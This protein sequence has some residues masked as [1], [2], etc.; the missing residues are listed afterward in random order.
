MAS[1]LVKPITCRKC[2]NAAAKF[3]C[4]TCKYELCPTCKV[5]HANSKDTTHHNIVPY[6]EKLNPKYLENSLCPKHEKHAPKFWCK[7][8]GVPICDSCIVSNEHIGHEFSDIT[9]VLSEQRDAML[10]ETMRLREVTVV[11][12]EDVLT[13]A[14]GITKDYLGS[15]EELEKA[16]MSRAKEM[17]E[18]VETILSK[19]KH[20]LQKMKADGLEKLKNQEKNLED[21]IHHLKADMERYEDQLRDADLNALIQFNQLESTGQSNDDAKPP[22]LE[23]ASLP[24][25]TKGQNEIKVMQNVFGQLS[26]GNTIQQIIELDKKCNQ[27]ATITSNSNKNSVQPS[28]ST[29]RDTGRSLIPNPSVQ[30]QFTVV[31]SPYIACDEQGQAWMRGGTRVSRSKRTTYSTLKLVGKDG[32]VKDETETKFAINDIAM[33]S[34]GC[35]LLANNDNKSIE[36]ISR[37]KIHNTLFRTS[38]VPIGLCCLHNNDIVVISNNVVEFHKETGRNVIIYNRN[39]EIRQTMDHIKL[40]YPNKVSVN[41]V[42]KHIYICD[43][44]KYSR[45]SVGKVIALGGDCE[46]KYEYTGQGD[47]KFT[48]LDV[49]TDQMGHVLITD[50]DNHR[51]HILDQEGQFMQYIL[52]SQGLL[53]QPVSIVDVD[54]DGYVWVGEKDSYRYHVKV[55]KYLH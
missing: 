31:S 16:L 7:T 9:A 2:D 12:W 50:H 24:V 18:E 40:K 49:C 1:D 55:V 51:V 46:I 6:A 10:A 22:S 32:S 3:Y 38:G 37:L 47:S 28:H 4:N 42:N 45:G 8:C 25:F 14:Q 21:K 52:T 41:K 33:T 26:T 19:S 54:S 39:G 43:Y 53:H 13:K 36:S 20:A 29:N 44:E 23:N 48:P 34:D 11:E 17:H 5:Q 30:Y 15:I 35:L 27:Q